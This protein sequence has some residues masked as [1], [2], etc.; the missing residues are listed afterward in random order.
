MP[1]HL[2]AARQEGVFKRKQRT[3][4][5]QLEDDVTAPT[6]EV[7]MVSAPGRLEADTF[8]R[9]IHRNDLALTF[10]KVEVAVDGCKSQT[11]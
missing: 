10:Q 2:K 7:V 1:D 9:Q 4:V 5:V 6:A 3:G 8:A 11:L